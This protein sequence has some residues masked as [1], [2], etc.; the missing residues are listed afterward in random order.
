MRKLFYVVISYIVLYASTL[1]HELA[2]SLLA[3]LFGIKHKIFDIH[4]TYSTLGIHENVDYQLVATLPDWQGI[5]IAGS[6]LIV[7]GFAIILGFCLL[8]FCKKM[9][10]AF[11][12]FAF[13]FCN[14]AVWV[15]YFVIRNSFPRGDIEHMIQ[16]GM[17]HSI[18]L[19]IGIVSSL[20]F[21]YLL[22]FP[23]RKY[24]N[25][26]FVYSEA[27]QKNKLR[28][29]IVIFIIFQCVSLFNDLFMY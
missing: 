20:F 5:L 10:S 21:I 11:I 12:V 7:N 27:T 9:L 17:P 26:Q 16:F 22:F 23:A 13:I 19:S 29:M 3:V 8:R 15:N 2:H 18:L 4:Y 28:I 24:I 6:G 14:V 25:T 1:F